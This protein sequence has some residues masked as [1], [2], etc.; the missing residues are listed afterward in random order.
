MKIGD[1][2]SKIRNE[3][4]ITQE[5]LAKQLFVSNKTIS[6]WELGR[7]EPNLEMII[8]LSECLECSINYLIYGNKQKDKTKSEIKIKLS[9][10][11]YKYIKSILNE[12]AKEISKSY[13]HDIYYENVSNCF[14]SNEYLR[15]GKRGK[16]NILTYKKWNESYDVILYDT[17][18]TNDKALEKI[19]N[20]IGLNKVVDVKKKRYKYVYNDFEVCLDNVEKLGYFIEIKSDNSKKL[21]NCTQSLRLNIKNVVTERYYKLI[22]ESINGN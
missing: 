14:S 16:K 11:E 13:Q 3:I 22:K 15:I 9:S 8:K 21:L 6:S 12:Y 7:T 20:I 10:N 2:I 5:D 19:F 18:I 4:N 1:R 17:E